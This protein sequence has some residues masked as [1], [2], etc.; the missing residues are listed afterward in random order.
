[1]RISKKTI[2]KHRAKFPISLDEI[3][4]Y[5]SFEQ[6]LGKTSKDYDSTDRYERWYKA[7]FLLKK[8]GNKS[9][10][11]FW[12]TISGSNET[13]FGCTHRDENRNWCRLYG[14]PP[15]YNPVLKNIGMACMGLGFEGQQE[16][17]FEPK[18]N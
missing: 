15:N 14:L 12:N 2:E 3:T 13:C 8:S 1:M 7:M 17:E 11:E 6:I 16:M 10:Y 18:N 5:S 9:S 4:F